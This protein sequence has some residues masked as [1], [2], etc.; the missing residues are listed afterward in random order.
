MTRKEKED[1][2]RDVRAMADQLLRQR[3]NRAIEALGFGGVPSGL[4]DVDLTRRLSDAQ[5]ILY[6]EFFPDGAGGINI[7]DFQ[8]SF[9]QFNNG[10]LRTGVAGEREPNGGYEFLFA[11]FAF[12]CIDSDVAK[13]EWTKILRVFV[14]TQEIFM[15]VYRPPPHGRPPPVVALGAL[16]GVGS[17]CNKQSRS[18]DT[19]DDR[20]FNTVGQSSAARKTA[21]RAKYARL[22]VPTLRQAARENLFRAQ[23]MT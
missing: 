16:V 3:D 4:G 7:A 14:Q 13:F 11:E 23:C 6:R 22:D 21:L 19:F 8:Q 1:R 9:E 15:H 20:N 5:L 2:I 12:L 18:L 17:P 10:E